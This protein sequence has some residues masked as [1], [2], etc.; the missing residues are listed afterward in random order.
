MRSCLGL[1]NRSKV[2]F[3]FFLFPQRIDRFSF[4]E[5][6]YNISNIYILLKMITTFSR[7]IWKVLRKKKIY[8]MEKTNLIL[9]KTFQESSSCGRLEAGRQ[10]LE[11]LTKNGNFSVF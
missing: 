10:L 5:G 6:F 2:D 9:L 11:D 8:G 4:V 7:R 3:V 1:R